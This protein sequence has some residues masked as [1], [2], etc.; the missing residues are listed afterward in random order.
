[1]YIIP[2]YYILKLERWKGNADGKKKQTLLI[3]RNYINPSYCPVVAMT[4]WL[5]VLDDVAPD[6]KNGP[7]FPALRDDHNWSII[8]EE[9]HMQIISEDQHSYRWDLTARYVGG[10]LKTSS[11]HGRRRSVV[12]WG[13]CCGCQA[14][15][16]READRWVPGST[17][18][19]EYWQDGVARRALERASEEPDPIYKVWVWE[20]IVHVAMTRGSSVALDFDNL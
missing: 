2:K 12:K 13:A 14:P 18:L 8:D 4:V 10:G 11:T 16:M 17:D 1:M 15:D 7:L 9:G 20:P 19:E 3:K 5:K 6:H